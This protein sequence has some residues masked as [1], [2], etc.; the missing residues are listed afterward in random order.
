MSIRSSKL[1]KKA[2]FGKYIYKV[3]IQ[4]PVASAFRG[5]NLLVTKLQIAM[6]VERLNRNG[7]KSITLDGWRRSSASPDDLRIANDIISI[8]ES[9]PD[10]TL[11][12]E[13]NTLGLYFNDKDVFDRIINIKNVIVEETSV[14][15]DD[16]TRDFLL[17][18]PKSIIRD[19]YTHK[20]KVTIA[21]LD[22]NAASFK[23]WAQ[24]LPKIK[25][26]GN[27]YKYGG[28]FYVADEKT[29]SLCRIYLSDK[30]RKV[31]EL[32]TSSE[33]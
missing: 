20:Y 15:A 33:I 1:T 5:K 11:R 3:A 19:E 29:L 23:E 26:T 10:F 4:L 28:H 2:F 6:L 25:T 14:P 31:E 8:L 32:V 13:Y 24:K 21:G 27:Q 12:V 18:S 22:H 30:I 9:V 17:T 7:N 16:K